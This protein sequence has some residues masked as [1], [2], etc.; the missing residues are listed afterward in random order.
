MTD[1]TADKIIKKTVN[2][3]MY[4]QVIVSCMV[5]LFGVSYA[6]RCAVEHS[7]FI[8]VFLF[9]C[10]AYVGYKLMLR[11]SLQEL[12]EHKNRRSHE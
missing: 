2:A 7:G 11:T 8:F 12:R 4:G 10:M 1:E 5:I 6:I 9:G 3:Y